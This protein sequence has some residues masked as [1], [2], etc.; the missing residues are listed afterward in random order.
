MHCIETQRRRGAKGVT[1]FAGHDAA[2]GAS[3][4]LRGEAGS[5]FG[6][7]ALSPKNAKGLMQLIPDT[8]ARFHVRNPYDPVQNLRGGIPYLRWVLAYFEGDVAL[9]A[10]ACNAGEGAV[11]RHRG[12]RPA[13]RRAYVRR[14]LQKVGRGGKSPSDASV[15]RPSPP[16]AAIR[17]PRTTLR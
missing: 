3:R 10:A 15:T 13:S 8:A 16:L 9:V 17:Q 6:I 5:N 1:K 12:P 11:V 7:V 14:I 2:N 4:A